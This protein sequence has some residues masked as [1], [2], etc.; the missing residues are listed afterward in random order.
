M[1]TGA[2]CRPKLEPSVNPS[3]NSWMLYR[4]PS[5]EPDIKNIPQSGPRWALDRQRP[6]TSSCRMATA[7]RACS[8][9]APCRPSSLSTA[10]R[11][12][13]VLAGSA[14]RPLLAS[15]TCK[16]RSNFAGWPFSGVFSSC[17]S[18]EHVKTALAAQNL[19]CSV[20]ILKGI[21][22]SSLPT[23]ATCQVCIKYRA[24]PS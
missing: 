3:S 4:K 19:A 7:A 22:W 23:K 8:S 15:S 20:E 2:G 5:F 24:G 12:S 14:A 6:L 1:K 10:Q 17:E 21:S 9:A 13:S 16:K 11:L 18:D